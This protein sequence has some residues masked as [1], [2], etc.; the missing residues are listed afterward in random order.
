MKLQS[1]AKIIVVL[2]AEI[3]DII[4]RGTF[5][6]EKKILQQTI[7]GVVFANMAIFWHFLKLFGFYDLYLPRTLLHCGQKCVTSFHSGQQQQG[8]Q[9][10]GQHLKHE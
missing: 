8:M 3:C 1:F 4:P 6:G 7:I 9:A 2:R 10:H 5:F